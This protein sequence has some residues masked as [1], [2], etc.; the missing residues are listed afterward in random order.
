LIY[1]IRYISLN[2]FFIEGFLCGF[3]SGYSKKFRFDQSDIRRLRAY[4]RKDYLEEL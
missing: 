4:N 2:K 3:R 1:K